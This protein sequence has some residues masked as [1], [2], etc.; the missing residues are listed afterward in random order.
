MKIFCTYKFLQ[1]LPIGPPS[2]EFRRKTHR[3]STTEFFIIIIIVDL[4][5]VYVYT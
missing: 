2:T 5:S 1:V 4:L 3:S